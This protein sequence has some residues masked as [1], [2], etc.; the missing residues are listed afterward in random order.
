MAC[1]RTLIVSDDVRPAAVGRSSQPRPP[2]RTPSAPEA[3]FLNAVL[4]RPATTSARRSAVW[5]STRSTLAKVG[6]D[7]ETWEKVVK[8]IR[9]GMMPPSGA[10]RPERAAL[11]AL[12]RRSSSRA[13]TKPSIRTRR[14]SRLRCID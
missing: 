1:S 6:P 4:H 2:A 13:S 11:D 5:R 8:K 7:A 10:R 9:T 14:S 12:R 3:A